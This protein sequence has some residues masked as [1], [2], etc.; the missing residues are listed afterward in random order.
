VRQDEEHIKQ[1]TVHRDYVLA[2]SA[3]L[4][5]RGVEVRSVRVS[6]GA[7]VRHADI[8][9]VV[10][11]GAGRVLLRWDELNGWSW[12][13]RDL[14][15]GPSPV[16][17]GVSVAPAPAYLADWAMMWLRCPVVTWP[18]DIAALRPPEVGVGR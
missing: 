3:E 10:P 11:G 9:L 12:Q 13:V 8:E 14:R 5:A 7:A 16:F 6:T 17:C 18:R 4:A 15:E 1:T 2:V